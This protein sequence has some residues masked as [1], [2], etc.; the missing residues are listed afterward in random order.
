MTRNRLLWLMF[1]AFSL[2]FISCDKDQ[3]APNPPVPAP[4]YPA[5]KISMYWEHWWGNMP[6]SME[7]DLLTSANDTLYFERA[8]YYITNIE[9]VKTNDS[10]YVEPESYRLMNLAEANSL[11]FNLSKVPTGTYKAI[12]FMMGVDSARN[13]SG[14]QTGALDPANGM[15]WSWSTGY[16]HF[17]LEGKYGLARQPFAY[18]IG[19]FRRNQVSMR[20]VNMSANFTVAQDSSSKLIMRADV[21]KTFEGPNPI[22]VRQQ[23]DVTLPGPVALGIADNVQLM[24]SFGGQQ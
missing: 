14:A 9:L 19:G 1:T 22:N 3:P 21:K 24:F 11:I 6:F 15:F 12:R 2:L 13:M 5:G 17:K 20:K 7:A 8:K 4:T 18:H 23:P 16:I 10:V